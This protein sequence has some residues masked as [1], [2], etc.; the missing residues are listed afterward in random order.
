LSV[1]PDAVRPV[2]SDDGLDHPDGNLNVLRVDVSRETL[3]RRLSVRAGRRN[4]RLR[5]PQLHRVGRSR[6]VLGELRAR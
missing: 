6:G 4:V 2:L 1:A 5:K 3:N